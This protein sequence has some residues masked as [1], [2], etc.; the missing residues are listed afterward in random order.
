MSDY[1][2]DPLSI[3]KIEE[4]A[5][6]ALDNCPRLESGAID[7]L[8]ALR[9]PTIKTRHG[10]K[11]LRL[12][13]VPDEHLPDKLAQVWARGDRVTVTVRMSLWNKAEEHDPDAL[14]ELRHEF[15][16]VY[17]H[18]GART[19]SAVTLDRQI[20]G[21]TVRN[22]IEKDH[23]VEW[24][25]DC[26]AACLGMPRS[27]ILPAMDVR[28]VCAEWNV[29]LDEARL[30]LEQIRLT[31]PKRVPDSVR[32]NIDALKASS[33]T[34]QVQALWNQLPCAPDRPGNFA[35]LARGFLVEYGQYNKYTQT[36]WA[37]EGGK[38]VPLM[39]KMES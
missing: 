28:D 8:S 35:K 38:V 2:V 3:E 9:S 32:R 15:G 12:K 26:F 30:R 33:I 13:L 6:Q 11:T 21:N 5:K 25:A 22:F 16:H 31:A 23:R 20:A 29:P 39:L 7:V 18:S 34:P 10:L 19:N 4:F 14:K 27:K 36:G 17:L 24:Q 37:I 1:T